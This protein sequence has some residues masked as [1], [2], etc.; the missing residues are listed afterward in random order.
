[1][2]KDYLKNISKTTSQEDAREESY[3]GDLSKF[4]SDFGENIGK[5]KI[6]ITT[7]F[8]DTDQPSEY[9]TCILF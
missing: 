9:N 1:M 4:L 3:Y 8:K 7:Q 2:I 5:S 6:Q